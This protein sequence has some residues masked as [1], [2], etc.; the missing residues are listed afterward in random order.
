MVSA[1][2]NE[3]A[4]ARMEGVEFRNVGKG[5]LLGRYAIYFDRLGTAHNSYVRHNSI[6]ESY[7]RAVAIHGVSNL[8]VEGNVMHDIKGHAVYIEAGVEQKNLILDNLVV[9]VKQSF[10]LQNT[11]MEP[12]AFYVSHPNNVLVGNAA[13]GSEGHGFW[14]DL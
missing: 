13:V 3:G 10:S 1:P 5:Y 8:R 2:G 9:T 11:D 14:Y 12:A 6:R 4:T 7:N